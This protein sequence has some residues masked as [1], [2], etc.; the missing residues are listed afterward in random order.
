MRRI[1]A[2]VIVVCS[3]AAVPTVAWA[4]DPF[5]SAPA[6]QA[7]PPRPVYHPRPAPRQDE[8]A[9]APLPA[10]PPSPPQITSA[11][12][13]KPAYLPPGSRAVEAQSGT[14]IKAASN[15]SFNR[16][17]ESLPVEITITQQPQ[18]GIITIE[19]GSINIPPQV[20]YGSSGFCVGRPITEKVIYY[21]S[22]QN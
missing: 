7:N 19:D 21:Q 14:V 15:Y 8:Q 18:N 12:L 2:F 11:P 10:Q 3:L 4:A 17:C 20:Q 22:N 1:K 16:V 5:E 9:P 6:P 13:L